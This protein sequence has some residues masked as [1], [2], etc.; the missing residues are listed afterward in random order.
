MMKDN[1]KYY[2][3][4]VVKPVLVYGSATGL[5]AGTAVF[6]FKWVAEWLTEK[7]VEI[8]HAAQ[9]NPWWIAVLAAGAAVLALIASFVQK[10]SSECR[11]G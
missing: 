7:S 6:F 3:G 1:Y 2:L 11:G 9:Q 5:V 8:Y 4:N 10:W